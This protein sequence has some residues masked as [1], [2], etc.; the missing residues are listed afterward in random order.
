MTVRIGL[1]G[2]GFVS[3]FYMQG[4]VEVP[5]QEIRVVYSR[6]EK[7]GQEFAKRWGIPEASTDMKAVIDR[8]DVDL[9]II[10]LPNEAHKEAALLAAA[11]RKHVVCTKPLAPNVRDAAEMLEA[12]EKAGIL[13]GYA[14]T[15]VFSPAVIR[16]REMIEAGGIGKVLTVRSREGH[17]GPHSPHFWDPSLTGGGA[18]MDLAPHTFEAARYFIGKDVKAVEVIAWGDL[19]HHKDKTTAEDNAVAMLRFEGGQLGLSELS[20]TARGGLDL[21][22]EVF[23]T[24]GAIFTDTTRSTPIHAFTLGQAGYLIEKADS[25]TGW[26]FPLPDEARVYG[27]HEEMRYFVECVRENKMPRESFHDGWV[28]NVI[29]EAAYRSMKTKKWEGFSI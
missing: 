10:A 1:L 16:G 13:H 15:E 8:S 6:S 27:Y 17:G 7:R 25:E 20:W 28:I 3:T 29:V 22:N 5:G 24:H 14:E 4:L 21:R 18:L 12:V 2:A 11:A 26:V 9:V 19:L 23:G